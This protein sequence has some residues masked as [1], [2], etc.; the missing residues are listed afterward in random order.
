VEVAGITMDDAACRSERTIGT[1]G[2]IGH[3]PGVTL[4]YQW[5]SARTC[6]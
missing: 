4:A 3:I 1:I 5:M 2:T 6:G